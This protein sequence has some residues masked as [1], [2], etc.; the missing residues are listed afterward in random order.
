[1]TALHIAVLGAGNIGGTLGR[2]WVA[3]GHQV[4]FGVTDAA[5]PRAQALRSDLGQGAAIG[6][7]AEAL[8]A[9]EVVVL[10]IPGGAIDALLASSAS[11]LD[12][13]V[14]VDATNRMGG[15]PMN[16]V[17]AISAAAPHA[18]VY[19]AFNSLGWENFAEPV[20]NGVQADLFYAGPG[21]GAGSGAQATVEQLISDIGLRPVYVG[22]P[23][24]V[25][26]V[27]AVASLWFALA[28]G[29]G[30]G[31]RLAFKTLLP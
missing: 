28:L 23:D 2:K 20:F 17:A 24:K 4:A 19:R 6:G 27:D 1:M 16:S 12:G 7:I 30:K 11:Q 3:A 22:G 14:I 31:R 8:A 29:Q 21:D 15:G 10:A 5:S 26:V 9:S 13:K 18:Q 25:A